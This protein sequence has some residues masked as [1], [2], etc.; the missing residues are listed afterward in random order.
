MNIALDIDGVI[1]D[2][3]N[4]F[5][6]HLKEKWDFV[7]RY[8]EIY[9][10]D[11]SQVLAL[12]KNDVDEIIHETLFSNHFKLIEGAKKSID[13]LNQSHNVYLITS[14]YEKYKEHTEKLLE[15]HNIQYKK[16][17]FSKY[18]EKHQVDIHFDVFVEDSV[19][20]AVSL[21]QKDLKI[22]LFNHPWNE[23]SLNLKNLFQRVYSWDEII[24]VIENIDKK[25]LAITP[26]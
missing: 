7:L 17:F 9:C 22:L 15:K 8:E 3:V 23:K 2:F 25:N 16:L 21:S 18:L 6:H 19:D 1:I 14:R 4:S 24:N 10:H 26:F 5:I 11:I 20:E 13:Q 12:P